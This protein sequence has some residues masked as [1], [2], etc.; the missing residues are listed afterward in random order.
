M[1]FSQLRSYRYQDTLLNE[2][3]PWSRHWDLDLDACPQWSKPTVKGSLLTKKSVG[4]YN[5]GHCGVSVYVV[6]T[7]VCMKSKFSSLW[8]SGKGS[9][10][11]RRLGKVTE[12]SLKVTE[13]ERSF[14]TF[15]DCK[16]FLDQPT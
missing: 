1:A 6:C 7:N 11:D 3:V 2:R 5:C 14:K 4:Y 16:V 8:S 13:T 12:R 10:N 15:S 9:G